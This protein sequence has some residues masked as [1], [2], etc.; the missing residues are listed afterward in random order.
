MSIFEVLKPNILHHVKPMYSTSRMQS[1]DRSING[2]VFEPRPTWRSPSRPFHELY[3]VFIEV[4]GS[5]R[6]W[7][8]CFYVLGL[9]L[10]H[11]INDVLGCMFDDWED[12]TMPHG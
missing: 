3:S 2:S 4:P 1:N 12:G 7:R 11:H 9:N 8:H 5:R 6:C 10:F